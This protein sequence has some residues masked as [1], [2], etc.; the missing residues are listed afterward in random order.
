MN[1][2][3]LVRP[4]K[5]ADADGV[6]RTSSEAIPATAEEREQVMNR[7]AEEVE[8]RKDRY[9]HFLEHDPEGAWVAVNG[10]RVVGVALALAREGVWI[11]SLFAVD[12]EYRGTGVGR[13]LLERALRYGEGCRGGML[14]SSTH[15]A[16]MRSYARAGFDLLP[17]L[18]AAGRVSRASVPAGLKAREGTEDDLQLAAE[19]DRSLRGASHGPDMEFML[20]TG[21]RL[22][23][24]ERPSGMGYAVGW[25]GSPAIVAAT[26][27]EIATDLLWFC[28]AQSP[29]AEVEARWITG[30]QNWAIPVVLRAGLSLS[31]A[32]PICIRGNLG[33]L[34][35][36]L[37]S[38]PFL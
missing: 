25:E 28:L 11:L 37:P 23:V 8:R 19:V 10:G 33:L 27:P 4:M 3:I 26:T 7:S 38:G 9:L 13:M 15:P 14:A 12:E 29:D 35:P 16:A 17:S 34:T 30:A 36:Y 24:A 21:C 31:P 32:G 20:R 18:V 5:I 2:S 1:H 22:F 6:Y